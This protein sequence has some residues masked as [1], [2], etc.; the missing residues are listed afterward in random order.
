MQR[1]SVDEVGARWCR[2]RAKMSDEE[3]IAT[4]VVQIRERSLRQGKE[5][6]EKKKEGRRK[7]GGDG[8]GD[9]K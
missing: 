3:E 8:G 1:M 9:Y 5:R 2:R 7:S 6:R 4:E